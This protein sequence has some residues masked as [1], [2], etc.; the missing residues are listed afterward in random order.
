MLNILLGSNLM[1]RSGR[2]C[3][4]LRCGWPIVYLLF[5]LAL[6][7]AVF[8]NF[9]DIEF[10]LYVKLFLWIFLIRVTFYMVIIYDFAASHNTA[11]VTLHKCGNNL[12]A[13]IPNSIF[14]HFFLST[15]INSKVKTTFIMIKFELIQQ[16][17]QKCS[18]K[19]IWSTTYFD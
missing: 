18:E 2:H 4:H 7:D 3:A 16:N 8:V 15:Y 5:Q 10:I 9:C 14:L 17:E 13:W 11:S 1:S 12:R 19:V 6:A